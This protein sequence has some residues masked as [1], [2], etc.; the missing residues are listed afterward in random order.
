[1]PSVAHFV[2]DIHIDLTVSCEC[3]AKLM[4]RCLI[5]CLWDYNFRAQNSDHP[6]NYALG[7]Y[8]ARVWFSLESINVA[9]PPLHSGSVPGSFY[10]EY[11]TWREA[12]Y[13][14]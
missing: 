10:G 11:L 3:C 5:D 9:Y 6:V 2:S 12:F 13:W 4:L 7:K 1:M 8:Q 14:S